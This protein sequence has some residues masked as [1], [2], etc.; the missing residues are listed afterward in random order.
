VVEFV[1]GEVPCLSKNKMDKTWTMFLDRDGLINEKINDNYVKNWDQFVFIEN[2]IEAIKLLSLNF[3]RILIVTNQRGVGKGLMTE[4]QLNIIHRKMCAQIE[5]NT[6]RIDK[7]YYCSSVFENNE[8]R[9]PNIGMGLQAKTDF[10]E[11]D[12]SKS[13]IIGDSLSDMKFGKQLGMH[14]LL[15]RDEMEEN[16]TKEFD[17]QFKSLFECALYLDRII[18]NNLD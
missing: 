12:F 11:I 2:A 14:C 3:N 17:L 15:I 13:I 8:N 7:I 5:L 1:R 18:S 4:E 10:P 9:K 6:G 16:Y